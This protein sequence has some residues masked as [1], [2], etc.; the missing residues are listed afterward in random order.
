M[1]IIVRSST[2]TDNKETKIAVGTQHTGEV[3]MLI[4]NFRITFQLF[5]TNSMKGFPK[6]SMAMAKATVM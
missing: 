1:Q 6:Y 5:I 2:G 3:G 4:T